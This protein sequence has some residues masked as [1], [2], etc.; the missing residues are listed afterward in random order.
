[1]ALGDHFFKRVKGNTTQ[2]RTYCNGCIAAYK[3]RNP[4]NVSAMSEAEKFTAE[5]QHNEDAMNTMGAGTR[6][7]RSAWVVHVLG[8]KGIEAC[9]NASSTAKKE[10]KAVDSRKSALGFA[11]S[12]TSTLKRP[13]IDVDAPEESPHKKKKSEMQST[14][15]A[16]V[17]KGLSI[18]FSATQEWAIHQQA[19]RVVIACDLPERFYE[20][21]EVK[22]LFAMFRTD[23]PRVLPS[24]K[25]IG[26]RL[27]DNEAARVDAHVGAELKGKQVVIQT[28][29][30]KRFKKGVTGV[31]CVTKGK[32]TTLHLVDT[33][34]ASKDGEAMAN[35]YEEIIKKVE[36]E[37][38]CIVVFLVTDAKGGSLRGRVV[39]GRRRPDL[40]LPSCF[41]HQSN[42]C[43]GDYLKEWFFAL[44]ISEEAMDL[45]GWINNH[46]KVRELFDK[47]QA[48]ISPDENNGRVVVVAYCTANTTRWTTHATSFLRLLR[49]KRSIR[50]AALTKRNAIIAA[51]VGA[52]KSTEKQRLQDEATEMCNRIDDC[53]GRFWNGLATVVGDLEPICLA[54]NINQQDNIRPDQVL[55]TFIGMFLHF[56]QHPEKE[57]R[58]G[59]TRR[60]EKR[61]KDADQPMFLLT[62]VLNPFE[63]L[64]VFGPDSGINR[65]KLLDLVLEVYRRVQS[66]PD[67]LDDILTRQK[68]EEAVSSAFL[69]YTVPAKSNAPKHFGTFEG[70]GKCP[71]KVWAAL[72]GP[73]L[74][75]SELAKL[76]TLLLEI[77]C[78]TA[79]AERL[80]SQ[81][82]IRL[83]DRK[84]RTKL[85]KLEKKAKIGEFLANEARREDSKK[86]PLFVSS[87]KR[88]N[89]QPN[90]DLLTVPRHEDL[91]R[92]QDHEDES[93]H[94]RALVSADATWRTE[95]ARWI[96]QVRQE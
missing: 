53:N 30:W 26:G 44:E 17:F 24:A 49:L 40:F 13:V 95:M 64:S 7:E 54:T 35:F 65:F 94:G 50:H 88:K 57:V 31:C 27:L 70:P 91:L 80:F 18:P 6:G 21:R 12:V 39:F 34:A 89:H 86:H 58:D 28:D 47:A 10:A 42:L 60:L 48:E 63:G 3:E 45:I 72:A 33:T 83:S 36:M 22:K 46:D 71:V 41:A 68:K 29:G 76:A 59:M 84:A 20:H 32:V 55:L 9:P 73:G 85:V 5:T 74:G 19:A 4:I 25:L 51:Q 96:G 1:M 82:K 56:A 92:D 79:G 37:K 67:N 2:W 43:C 16:K 87:R 11:Q 75:E 69:E 62:L 66:R 14:L 78:H 52:A 38:G 77:V 61:W 93:E 15:D 81:L 23:G 8:G 90:N